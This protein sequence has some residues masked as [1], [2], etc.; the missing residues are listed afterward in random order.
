MT[1]FAYK[2]TFIRFL[3]TK[4]IFKK[5]KKKNILIYDKEAEKILYLI[6]KKEDCEIL[7]VR[8]ESINLYIILKTLFRDG[9][10]NFKNNYKLN[11]SLNTIYSIERF[12]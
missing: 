5:P 8:Y 11:F 1:N 4:W 3:M 9:I 10:L 12:F 6:Y 7:N 2:L